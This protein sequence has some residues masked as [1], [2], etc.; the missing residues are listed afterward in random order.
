M[1]LWLPGGES[2]RPVH[3]PR[4]GDL[5]L[6]FPPQGS[7]SLW[8]VNIIIYIWWENTFFS[9]TFNYMYQNPR[10]WGWSPTGWR[11]VQDCHTSPPGPAHHEHPG[12]FLQTQ[13]SFLYTHGVIHLHSC[14]HYWFSWAAQVLMK[15]LICNHEVIRLHSCGH[16]YILM[17]SLIYTHEE[18]HLNSSGSSSTYTHEIIHLYS[19]CH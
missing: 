18:I 8:T 5:W 11:R 13:Q 6:H 10:V 3:A 19:W 12:P 14:S 7:S 17:R 15:S 4:H 1:L 16:L 2:Q 9:R